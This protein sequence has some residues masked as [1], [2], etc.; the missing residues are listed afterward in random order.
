VTTKVAYKLLIIKRLVPEKACAWVGGPEA[1]RRNAL[2]TRRFW[3]AGGRLLI[4]YSFG[5]FVGL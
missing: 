2:K 5:A 3:R 4:K 1:I